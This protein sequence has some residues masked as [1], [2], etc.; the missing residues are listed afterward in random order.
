MA[1]AVPPIMSPPRACLTDELGV[2]HTGT[3]RGD[4]SILLEEFI[5]AIS[6]PLG[7]ASISLVAYAAGQPDETRGPGPQHLRRQLKRAIVEQAHARGE[8]AS[9]IH[10]DF[11]LDLVV[12]PVWMS[13]LVWRTPLAEASRRRDRRH[14]PHGSVASI[15]RRPRCVRELMP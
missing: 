13:L 1:K 4:L 5:A 6:A 14:R 15:P 2:R 10:P 9:E 3:F 11:L 12:A 8:L 7:R